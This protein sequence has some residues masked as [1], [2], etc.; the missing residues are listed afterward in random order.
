MTSV[1]KAPLDGETIRALLITF[2]S[3]AVVT[4]AFLSWWGEGFVSTAPVQTDPAKMRQI[5][6]T[7]TLTAD[8]LNRVE[9]AGATSPEAFINRECYR[10]DSGHI[11]GPGVG[12]EW[13]LSTAQ[14]EQVVREVKGQ[15]LRRGWRIV[16]R[17]AP[18]PSPP[19]LSE[20]SGKVF[21]REELSLTDGG[22]TMG[23]VIQVLGDND[24]LVFAAASTETVNP[25]S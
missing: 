16:P 4:I 19:P 6:G 18:E 24:E 15:L 2:V 9:V 5:E 22:V 20:P 7:L 3:L 10:D 1:E 23:M 14:P 17:E 21:L 13:Q 8:H 12:R 25:C 11:H